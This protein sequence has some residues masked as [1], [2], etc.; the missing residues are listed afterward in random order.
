[1]SVV[2][3]PLSNGGVTLVDSDIAEQ[4][5]NEN[6]ARNDNLRYVRVGSGKNKRYI[7][8]LIM[9]PPKGMVV[10]H[11]NGDQTDNRR[12]N[13]RI[14]TRSENGLN[15]RKPTRAKSGFRYVYRSRRSKR[16]FCRTDIKSKSV[17]YWSGFS[18]YI[19]AIFS[20]QII[21]QK[22]G[23]F[24]RKNFQKKISSTGLADFLKETH[25]RIFMV[26]FSRRSDG[27]QREMLC[28]TGVKAHQEGGTIPFDPIS[29]G[30]FS[31]YDVQ[32]RSYRFIPLENVICIRFAKTNYRVVA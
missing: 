30:L 6:I 26:V 5:A 13:L 21:V 27:M 20:D 9:N 10:D 32:K 3:L 15:M 8:R 24:A 2:K 23:P 14:C 12:S 28:R 1:M 25:G 29:L 17:Y 22:I 16:Y 11:L 18:R 4:F 31:V 19:A 7:H